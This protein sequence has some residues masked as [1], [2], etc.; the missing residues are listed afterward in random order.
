MPE[1]VEVVLTFDDGPHAGSNSSQNRTRKVMSAL[2]SRGIRGVF[3]IQTHAQDAD[4]NYYR[5]N[6]PVGRQII[7][8][9]LAD[10]YLV[11]IHTGM[12]GEGAHEYENNHDNRYPDDLYDDL[13]RAKDF[14]NGQ[15]GTVE[16]VRPP[17]GIANNDVINMYSD[18]A[19]ESVLWDVAPQKE[20]DSN[21]DATTPEEVK[22]NIR[23]QIGRRLDEGKR[24][25][26]VL[27]HDV[28]TLVAYH[29]AS[30]IT[31]IEQAITDKGF[32]PDMYHSKRRTEE[33]LR[34]QTDDN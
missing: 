28:H 5:G 20:E 18:L 30:Y 23:E 27:L 25:V 34:D 14:I 1:K 10:G 24:K 32:T 6:T 13:V 8:D 29:I 12:D 4:E 11:E 19:L 16:F 7:R 31:E 22:A 3:F 21:A 15:G 2:D 17:F 9:M 33:I 26:V